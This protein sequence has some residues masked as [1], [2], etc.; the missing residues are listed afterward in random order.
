MEK[1]LFSFLHSFLYEVEEVNI[2]LRTMTGKIWVRGVSDSTQKKIAQKMLP[3]S[4]NV[5]PDLV[6]KHRKRI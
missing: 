1:G 3:L 4:C 2:T 5:K 6:K